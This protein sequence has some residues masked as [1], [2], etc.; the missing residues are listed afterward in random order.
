MNPGGFPKRILDSLRPTI[1]HV[2][3]CQ[4]Y[5]P[6]LGTLN[7]R[8]RSIIGTQK[9]A[10]ILTTTHVALWDKFEKDGRGDFRGIVF[11]TQVALTMPLAHLS[12]GIIQP[13][14]AMAGLSSSCYTKSVRAS[15]RTSYHFQ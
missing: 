9:G 11:V 7:N 13:L 10:L 6:F 14:Q 3:G 12:L 1:V 2:G 5:G 15:V 8:C 4:N